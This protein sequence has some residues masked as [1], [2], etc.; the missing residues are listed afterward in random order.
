MPVLHVLPDSRFLCEASSA[1][2][3]AIS[4]CEALSAISLAIFSAKRN[5]GK[6]YK[7]KCDKPKTPYQRVLDDNVLTPEQRD[8]LKAYKAKLSGLE[9]YLQKLD[10]SSSPVSVLFDGCSSIGDYTAAA[11]SGEGNP[12]LAMQAAERPLR[13]PA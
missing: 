10:S 6:G 13:C 5:D 11:A 1:G 9:L 2:G 12:T 7:C 3:L 4:L 8:T